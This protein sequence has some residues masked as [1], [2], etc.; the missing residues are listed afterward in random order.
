[1]VGSDSLQ[2]FADLKSFRPLRSAVRLHEMICSRPIKDDGNFTEPT[3]LAVRCQRSLTYDPPKARPVSLTQRCRSARRIWRDPEIVRPFHCTQS[4]AIEDS[5]GQIPSR[6]SSVTIVSPGNVLPLQS[7]VFYCLLQHLR[8]R[9][10]RERFRRDLSPSSRPGTFSTGFVTIVARKR[11]ATA[12]CHLPLSPST[13]PATTTK[14]LRPHK[15]YLPHP[16]SSPATPEPAATFL[17][18]SSPVLLLASVAHVLTLLRALVGCGWFNLESWIGD[19]AV[20]LLLPSLAISITSSRRRPSRVICSHGLFTFVGLPVTSSTEAIFERAIFNP[21]HLLGATGGLPTIVLAI[22]GINCAT[23]IT[24]DALFSFSME[25]SSLFHLS[26]ISPSELALAEYLLQQYPRDSLGPMR[27]RLPKWIKTAS[28]QNLVFPF[29]E[30]DK[31]RRK[32][33]EPPVKAIYLCFGMPEVYRVLFEAFGMD[34]EDESCQP[35]LRRQFEDFDYVSIEFEGKQLSWQDVATYRPPKDALF[36]HPRLF[37]AF[38]SVNVVIIFYIIVAMGEPSNRHQPDP[39][40]LADAK[41]S[42]ISQSAAE[43][44]EGSTEAHDEKEDCSMERLQSLWIHF[45]HDIFEITIF[46]PWICLISLM[47][48][49]YSTTLAEWKSCMLV[50]AL[51]N[52]DYLVPVPYKGPR[53]SEIQC[54]LLL[55]VDTK[56]EHVI[57]QLVHEVAEKHTTI[58]GGLVVKSSDE[59]FWFSHP[60][61]VLHLIHLILFQNAFEIA[62]FFWILETMAS[63]LASWEELV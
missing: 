21:I 6:R 57:T 38:I 62:Y 17:S 51:M 12:V 11:S 32:E 5:L 4:S 25:L 27:E 52:K 49:L 47:A 30:I 54:Q 16:S 63:I 31:L 34:P 41:A 43:E 3:L 9:F 29:D 19:E 60:K 22:F 26:K 13:S 37:R 61:I 14:S 10:R 59:H 42:N 33:R 23:I 8:E 7:T 46:G 45:T 44:R 20:F 15:R 2:S 28:L 36:A 1:M 53:W 24:M 18:P 58:E 50:I 48:G 55:V 35:R 39:S 40:F 56:L